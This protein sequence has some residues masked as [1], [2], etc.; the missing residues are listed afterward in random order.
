MIE[1][2]TTVASIEQAQAVLPFVD[3]I[4]FGEETFALRLPHS[5]DRK[6]QRELVTLAHQAGKK[7]QVAVNGI[8]HPEKMKLIPEYL[9][10]LVE[11]GVDQITVGEPGTIFVMKKNEA[12]RIPFIYAG[13]TL[14][15][16]ARQINFWAKKG[17]VGAILAR[18]VPFEEMQI[19][20]PQLSVPVE[21]LV[22]GGT[23][24]H[25]SKRPLLQNYYNFTSQEE[26]KDRARDLFL[27]EP[28]KDETHYSIFED[29]HGTH[30]FAN[31]DLNLMK[32][33][34]ELADTGFQTWKLDGILNTGDSF[35]EIVK[36]F[37]QARQA[38]ENK[39][40]TKEL[41]EELNAQIIAH[42]PSNRGLDTGFYYIDPT[43]IK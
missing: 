22:Y 40:W 33:L 6:E 2:I 15:T 23:C 17:A 41:A 21:V 28:K 25:H 19:M 35:V 9:A 30:V 20:A 18:E 42:H 31:N 5:F 4:Y 8:M 32:E 37:D 13:E 36:T 38:I 26:G 14:V 1:I 16:S 3:T 39:T 10:F 34:K 7:A 12:L 27:S 24:I 11:I 43:K 29:S